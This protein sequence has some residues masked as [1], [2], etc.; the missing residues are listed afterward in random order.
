[1]PL[2][3]LGVRLTRVLAFAQRMRLAAN[4]EQMKTRAAAQIRMDV[5]SRQSHVR[6][7]SQAEIQTE[8]LPNLEVLALRI[9]TCAKLAGHAF[10]RD[11]LLD[12]IRT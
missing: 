2:G 8:T 5:D 7:G 11:H 4:G 1:M 10:G 6:N 9:A 12:K 3:V